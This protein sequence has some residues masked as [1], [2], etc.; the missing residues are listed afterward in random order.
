MAIHSVFFFIKQV[1]YAANKLRP[2]GVLCFLLMLLR[3]LLKVFSVF[4]CQSA[5]LKDVIIKPDA[6][7]SLLLDKHADYIAAYGSKKDDYVSKALFT[8]RS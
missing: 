5:Q 8:P 7:S 3:G 1:K 4:L 2:F 6:P